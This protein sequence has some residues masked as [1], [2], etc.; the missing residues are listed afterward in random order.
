MLD[1]E[2]CLFSFLTVVGQDSSKIKMF[3]IPRECKGEDLTA[4]RDDYDPYRLA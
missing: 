3:Y 1:K 2:T 4:I